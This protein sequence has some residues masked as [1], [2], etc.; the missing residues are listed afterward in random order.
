MYRFNAMSIKIPMTF[1]PELEKVILK[2]IQNHNRPRI[3]MAILRKKN[4]VGGSMCLDFKPYYKTIVIKTSWYWHKNRHKNQWNRVERPE[5]NPCLHSQLLHD[6]EGK[7]IQF[8][9]EILIKKWHCL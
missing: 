4:K 1:F 8:Y 2:F 9:K 5:I 3:A 6:K 7:N